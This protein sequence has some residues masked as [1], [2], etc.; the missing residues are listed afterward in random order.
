MK[1]GF[2]KAAAAVP[3]I[4]VA[5]CTENASSIISIIG[6]AA[7][8]GTELLLLPELCVTSCSCGELYT[9]PHLLASSIEALKAIAATTDGKSPIAAK[10]L[11]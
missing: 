9:H 4:S 7:K 1:Y 3:T 8:A 10:S 11:A 2:V 5:D 6:D